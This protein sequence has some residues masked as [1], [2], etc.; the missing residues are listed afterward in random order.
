MGLSNASCSAVGLH[1]LVQKILKHGPE[2][3][4]YNHKFIRRHGEGAAIN[5]KGAKIP[6]L[7]PPPPRLLSISRPPLT[8]NRPLAACKDSS[9]RAR[10]TRR[11][12]TGE[13]HLV[14]HEIHAARVERSP[15][16]SLSSDRRGTRASSKSSLVFAH[17]STDCA[18]AVPAARGR[19]SAAGGGLAWSDRAPRDLCLPLGQVSIVLEP[20][21]DLDGLHFADFVWRPS[22]AERCQAQQRHTLSVALHLKPGPSNLLSQAEMEKACLRSTSLE[23]AGDCLQRLST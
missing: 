17:V 13:R 19:G 9:E 5:F 22:G 21:E 2:M 15:N 12:L 20:F 3:D 14:D 23:R 7:T 10:V 8:L 6:S 16:A 11:Y 18:A 4:K 1:E